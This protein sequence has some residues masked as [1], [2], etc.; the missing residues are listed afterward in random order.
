MTVGL[1]TPPEFY[2]H[3][4][5]FSAAFFA[6][7]LGICV[8]QLV[9]WAG[10]AVTARGGRPGHVIVAGGVVLGVLLLVVVA[11]LVE[12][13]TTYAASYL[14]GAADPAPTVE[15][16]TPEGACVIFD[17]AVF[18]TTA[19]RF[20]PACSGCPAVVDPFGMW[21]ARDGGQP[22][23]TPQPYPAD[24]SGLWMHWLTQAD[25]V[26]LSVPYSNYIPWTRPMETYFA[27]HYLLVSLQPRTYVYVH[28]DRAPAGEAAQWVRRGTEA[29]NS[30]RMD[31]AR[32][33]F[34]AALAA[35]PADADATFDV[36]VTF[37]QQ[38]RHAEAAA[39]YRRAFCS[40][41][42]GSRWRCTT[43]RC[44]NRRR[45]RPAPLIFIGGYSRSS[46][47]TPARS[48]TSV[49]SSMT[50]D[51]GRKAVFCC[52]KPLPPIRLSRARVPTGVNVP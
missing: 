41:I 38:G 16:Q 14:G 49:C 52:M 32:T 45:L 33:D 7:L 50:Q 22:P 6:L 4:A 37:Q 3:Y 21:L 9:A 31:E 39:A 10:M 23:G 27:R 34:E 2:D 5:Y 25:Y 29:L 26:V 15:A 47:K 17:Y 13:D 11:L 42:R 44:S 30:G 35:D 12:Q 51:S 24:F 28:Y 8:S 46:R 1:F 36:G 48:T 40:S 19:N 20:N 18:A 43:L